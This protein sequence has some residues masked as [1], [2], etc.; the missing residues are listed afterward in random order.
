MALMHQGYQLSETKDRYGERAQWFSQWG[1]DWFLS[2]SLTKH[3]LLYILRNYDGSWRQSF[4]DANR[5]EYSTLE[6]TFEAMRKVH[7]RQRL[8]AAKTAQ[9][10]KEYVNK[11]PDMK[12]YVA[13]VG[14][15]MEY[16]DELR[17]LRSLAV[18]KFIKGC[19]HVGK[20]PYAEFLDVLSVRQRQLEEKYGRR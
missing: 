1:D 3:I 6:E 8:S 11:Y 4:H 7:E 14:D 2:R 16:N 20:E 10:V 19:E 17:L 13:F 18:Y 15:A 5:P 12:N 9:T